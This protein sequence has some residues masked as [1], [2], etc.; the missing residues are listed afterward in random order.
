MLAPGF[1]PFDSLPVGAV[2]HFVEGS[3]SYS[4][5]SE[6]SFQSLWDN[7][8]YKNK[9]GQ[10]ISCKVYYSGQ[11]HFPTIVKEGAREYA[12]SK[13]C[14]FYDL[15]VGDIFESVYNHLVYIKIGIFEYKLHP[16][17]GDT[18]KLENYQSATVIYLGFDFQTI[19]KDR[20]DNA[21]R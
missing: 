8:L 1:I 6:Y 17:P 12:N 15:A 2:F 16:G 4:K 14:S 11:M 18:F 21:N 5:I 3:E 19:V 10:T 9:S 7:F 20:A 13:T